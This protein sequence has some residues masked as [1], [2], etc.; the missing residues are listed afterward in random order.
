MF[1]TFETS[2]STYPQ[3]WLSTTPS[4]PQSQN[5]SFLFKILLQFVNLYLGIMEETLLHVLDMQD[6]HLP[7]VKHIKHKWL[8]AK[9]WT[10]L[11]KKRKMPFFSD[12]RTCESKQVNYLYVIFEQHIHLESLFCNWY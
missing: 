6:L 2:W 12:K 11:M 5:I 7:R 10:C 3:H 1:W 8:I 9:R 4:R